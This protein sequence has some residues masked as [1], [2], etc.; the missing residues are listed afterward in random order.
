M[1]VLFSP[2]YFPERISWKKEEKEIS[3]EM[4]N[5]YNSI[6]LNECTLRVMLNAGG[7]W[8]TMVRDW[9][10]VPISCAPGETSTITIPL[11]HEGAL[12]GLQNGNPALCRCIFLD[13]KGFSPITADILII[14]EEI[15]EGD[16]AMP[17]GPD[18]EL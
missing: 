17:I 16:N 2:V 18:A 5:Q 10:D 15:K 1:R 13:P 6:D 4:A 8:M 11:N 9:Q 12:S 14:P 3:F 7:K